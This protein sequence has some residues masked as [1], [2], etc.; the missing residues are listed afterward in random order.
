MKFPSGISNLYHDQSQIL[1]QNYSCYPFS[2]S[3]KTFC[4][5][6]FQGTDRKVAGYKSAFWAVKKVLCQACK[7]V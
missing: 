4:M 6:K 7:V 3:R 2:G 1:D 5:R